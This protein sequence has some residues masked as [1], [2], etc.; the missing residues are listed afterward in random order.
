M[1]LLK[2]FFLIICYGHLFA[3]DADFS[4]VPGIVVAYS[5]AVSKQY[6]GSPSIAIMDNG[7]YIASHDVFG[8]N[9]SEWVQAISKIYCS[10]DK[11]KSWRKISEIKGAFW[12]K[13]F[14]HRGEL[15]FIG[16]DRHHGSL[17]IRKSNDRGN[18]WTEPTN[19]NNGLLLA[20][21]YHSAPT[22]VIEHNGRLWRA[23]EAADG[24]V[25]EW[26]LRYGNFMMSVPVDANL[27]VSK[28]WTKS[29]VLYHDSTYLDGK[30]TAWIE[31]NAIVA[32]DGEIW[33]ILRVNDKKTEKAAIVKVSFDGKKSTFDSQKGFIDFPGGSKKFTIQ[34]D[35]ITKRY[36]ALVNY[37]PKDEQSFKPRVN[38]AAIRNNLALVSSED[39][40]KWQ[41]HEIVLSHPDVVHHAFQYVDWQF[42]NNDII[43]LSRT[44][45]E[46]GNGGVIRAHD[47]NFLTFHR[48]KNFR[49][50]KDKIIE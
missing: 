45:Y 31:G 14:S 49:E 40:L 44:G 29:N 30:F 20:G 33:N 41:V 6:I 36:W 28:N 12:S 19:R 25:K 15:Y 21:E 4:K 23:V 38:P 48:V 27:L 50:M 1:K 35:K 16:P 43:F 10:K 37:I 46:D 42:E 3:Q 22:P 8:P 11:G 17:L 2:T 34:Y 18:T 26:G 32:P 13:L 7:D 47:A 39:L 9:S 5:P 24:P